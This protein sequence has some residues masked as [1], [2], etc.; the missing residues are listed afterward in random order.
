[1]DQ[2]RLGLRKQMLEDRKGIML[3][4][5]PDRMLTFKGSFDDVN[6]RNRLI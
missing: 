6:S 5:R 3:L 2:S 1:M 4:M